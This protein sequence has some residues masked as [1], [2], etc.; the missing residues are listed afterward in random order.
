MGEAGLVGKEIGTAE[1][2]WDGKASPSA[3]TSNCVMENSSVDN[4]VWCPRNLSAL[5]AFP[6]APIA[7]MRGYDRRPNSLMNWKRTSG[8][9]VETPKAE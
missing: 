3:P 1:L 6:T 7:S 9:A 4:W 8:D 5:T 2:A